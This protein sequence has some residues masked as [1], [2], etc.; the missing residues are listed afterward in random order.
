MSN[1]APTSTTNITGFFISVRGFSFTYESQNARV[2]ICASQIDLPF[3]A[4]AVMSFSSS[5]SLARIHQQMFENRAEAEGGE[6][7]QRANDQNYGDEQAG[8]QRCGHRKCTQ[9]FRHVLLLGQA[10]CN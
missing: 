4:W 10:A 1:A 8:E 7:S 2:A 9:R 5:K 6:K 3:L